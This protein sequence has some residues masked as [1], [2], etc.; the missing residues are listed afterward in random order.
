MSE[1]QP[2]EPGTAP[3]Y[4]GRS[5]RAWPLVAG[6]VALLLYAASAWAT[7]HTT[8][9]QG[10]YFDHLAEAFLHGRLYLT[11]PPG[12]SDLTLHDGRWYVAFP[13]LAAI[14]MMPWVAVV[15]LA[16][17]NP[18]AF[19]MVWAAISV[20]LVAAMLERLAAR[21]WIRL[22][23]R[24]R[25]WLVL[26]FAFG[27]VY[28]Q[29]ALE[30]SV[31][32]LAH[33]A[34]VMFVALAAYLA[35]RK[36]GAAL[37]SAALA[38]ALWSRPTV[39]FTWP[40]LLGIAIQ[41][42]RDAGQPADRGWLMRWIACSAVPLAASI[43]GLAWYN[44]ARFGD[45]LDFGYKTQNVS[46]AVRGELAQGQFH[47]RH[48]PRNLHVLLMAPPRW[49]EPSWAPHLHVPV[50]DDRGMSIFL[51]TPALLYVFRARRR[52]EPL[53]RG[54]WL[55][56]GLTLVPLLLYYNTGWR[57]FG[58]RFSLDFF[59]PL[60]ILLAVAVGPRLTRVMRFWIAAGVLINAW[61]VIWWYTSW[62]E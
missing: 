51:T 62:L 21:R 50:P 41:H 56:V 2:D 24:G 53:V 44:A 49:D 52:R 54:A 9:R 5:H 14:L 59:I 30:G 13:P 28:W 35:V 20:A 42:R 61:G 29:V 7:G 16:R 6:L 43:A 46:A 47:V 60:L 8:V 23:F 19:S 10:S 38:V 31:W 40:L 32:F 48:I 45:P 39:L 11:D 57:Q 26:L 1:P 17:T 25:C 22:D 58:Y 55:A 4:A 34:A 12:I 3:E 15:G 18:V 33:V 36:A 27:C 37:P